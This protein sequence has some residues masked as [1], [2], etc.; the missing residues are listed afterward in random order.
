MAK[1]Y[2]CPHC[3]ARNRF[4]AEDTTDGV[5]RCGACTKAFLLPDFLTDEP[6]PENIDT[7][8]IDSRTGADVPSGGF[9][10][11]D[12]AIVHA[13]P[14]PATR[15]S[16]RPR[17]VAGSSVPTLLVHDRPP[18]RLGSE[19][20]TLLV[21]GP[22]VPG[23]QVP[24]VLVVD[25]VAPKRVPSKPPIPE[26]DTQ[27]EHR[28]GPSQ[29]PTLLVEREKSAERPPQRRQPT[30][31][32]PQRR[33]PTAPPPSPPPPHDAETIR[34]SEV[35][36]RG[37]LDEDS[38]PSIR[39]TAKTQPTPPPPE[40]RATQPRPTEDNL[41]ST[42]PAVDLAGTALRPMVM[43]GGLLLVLGLMLGAFYLADAWTASTT[44]AGVLNWSTSRAAARAEATAHIIEE[45]M[46][47][48]RPDLSRTIVRAAGQAGTALVVRPDGSEA[49]AEGD[50]AGYQRVLR[51]TCDVEHAAG[52][53]ETL[54]AQVTTW[55]AGPDSRLQALEGPACAPGT[56]VPAERRAGR[57]FEL[58]DR[59]SAEPVSWVVDRGDRR[60]QVIVHPIP[61]RARC[62]GCHPGAVGD[63]LGYVV[64]ETSLKPLDSILT[65]N[66]YSLMVTSFVVSVLA[67]L[68]LLGCFRFVGHR[69]RET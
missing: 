68:V 42:Q 3:D 35:P 39:S 40:Y 63:N 21:S 37:L 53:S 19:T 9:E 51:A 43:V 17:E 57:T 69:P 5:V 34:P 10:E 24:T 49:F 23:S 8:I 55:L 61:R 54:G 65:E 36:P 6:P 58:G 45:T 29:T 20:P 50:W 22:S 46:L 67:A 11:R 56:R 25:A 18:P 26:V 32:P 14:P 41:V 1:A 64:V 31:P 30:A 60:D 62:V 38:Q 52:L 16:D 59:A 27:P 66:R 4:R 44:E 13:R 12:T 33:Q 2:L 28:V 48:G 15:R 7:A 47:A